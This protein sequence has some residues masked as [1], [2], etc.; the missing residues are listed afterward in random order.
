MSER[1]CLAVIL[2]AGEGT[3]MR[4]GLPKVLHR[5]GGLPLIGH[6]VRA[7]AMAGADNIAVVVGPGHDA[8]AEAARAEAPDASVFVQ[9]ERLGTAHA[10]LAARDALAAGHDDLVIVFGDTPFVSPEAIAALRNLVADGAAVAVGGMRPADPDGYGR[11]IMDGERLLAIREDGDASGQ[12]RQIGFCNGGL[13]AMSGALALDILE[14][15]GTD[16]AQ[17]EYYLPDAVKIANDRRLTVSAM[18]I[19]AA[20]VF[21]INTRGHLA[22]AEAR[23]QATQRAQAMTGGATLVAPETVFFSHDTQVGRDVTIEPNVFIGSGVRI[24]DGATIRA[25][26]HL[27]GATIAGGAIIGPFARLRPGA[28]IGQNAR[29]GNFC[30]VKNAEVQE[31]AKINHLTYIGDAEIGARAN[32]GAGTITCNYDGANKYRTTIGENA[33][34]GSNSALVAPVT[35]GRGAYVGSGS[36]ITK[37]VPDDALA[38]GR[39]RQVTKPDWAAKNRTKSQLK[40]T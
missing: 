27:E 28:N 9:N 10:V 18:E 25:F 14:A 31:A 37:D 13:M 11:L 36:V 24:E 20:E 32:I 19:D 35:I 4:S 23:F 22:E 16:N 21:G 33:F 8:V 30:E 38:V 2:A 39:G 29:V 3:R 40:K 1:T 6:V 12:E 15:I 26:C 17:G 34:I 7:V 5:L